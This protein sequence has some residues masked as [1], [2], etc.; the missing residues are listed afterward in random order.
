VLASLVSYVS[1]TLVGRSGGRSLFTSGAKEGPGG[2]FD[3]G[4]WSQNVQ[5]VNY[6]TM[7]NISASR[8]ALLSRKQQHCHSL[9][10]AHYPAKNA[11][12]HLSSLDGDVRLRFL[13]CRVRLVCLRLCSCGHVE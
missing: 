12:L 8:G 13:P 4:R 2:K 7:T 3:W 1:N 6:V 10:L 11:K 9:W 5:A